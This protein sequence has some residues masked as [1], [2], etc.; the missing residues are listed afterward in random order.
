MGF[1]ANIGQSYKTYSFSE[2]SLRDDE[3]W[4]ELNRFIYRLVELVR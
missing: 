1:G 4:D 3:S 2:Q